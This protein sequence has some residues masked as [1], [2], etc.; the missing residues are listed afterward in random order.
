MSAQPN[1]WYVHPYA[2]GPGVGRLGRPFEL[3]R[4]WTASGARATVFTAAHN[5]AAYAPRAAGAEVIG[6]VPYAFVAAP[7]YAG[8]GLGR[9]R[10]MAAFTWNLWRGADRHAREFGKPTAVVASSPHPYAFFATHGI[11]RRFGALSAFEVRDLWPLSLVELAGVSPWHPFVQFTGL[12]ERYAHARADRVVSLL[13][14][15]LDHM[16]ARGLD[17]GKWHYVPNGVDASAIVDSHVPSPPLHR[18]VEWQAEGRVVAVYAGALGRP[19]NV[20]S[21]VDGL[22]ALKARGDGTLTA[23]IVG[24]GEEENELAARIAAAGV[25]DRVALFGQVS[26]EA[27][28][29]LIARA[30]IG[31]I[32]L[33]PEPIFR[34]GVSPNKLLDYMLC[35]V[36]VVS[37][38]EAG[39]DPVSDSGCGETVS[40]DDP[41]AIAGAL[42]RLAALPPDERRAIGTRGRGYVLIEH[43]YDAIARVYLDLLQP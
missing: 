4:R 16:R 14:G 24:R 28:L 31:Y 13:P 32:S 39:N 17:P 2:G 35:G 43:D 42:Q 15:T 19:N 5:H 40:P 8:N 12:V 41:A 21:L 11:A 20:G 22:A 38:I 3:G 26:K 27:A 6:G 18:L 30:D 1:I 36:P 25:G 7:T 23:I 33:R 37:A 10:N 34:F 9:I 29:S